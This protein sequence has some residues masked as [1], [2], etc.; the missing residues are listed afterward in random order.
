[1][2]PSVL[3]ETV[4][5]FTARE[6]VAAGLDRPVS[7]DLWRRLLAALDANGWLVPGPGL[8]SV[9]HAGA[10]LEGLSRGGADTGVPLTLTVHYVMTFRVLAGRSPADLA[11]LRKTPGLACMGASE[12]KVGSH[13]AKIS[14][15]ARLDNGGWVLNGLKV[16]TTGGPV[17]ERFLVMAVCG[18]SGGRRDLGVL[19]VPRGTEGFTVSEMPV[20]PGLE[21][22]PHGVLQF[23]NV[24][25]PSGARLDT[26]GAG[27][28]GWT[29]IVK[30]FRQWEDALMASWIAGVAERNAG[31]LAALL[32]E[33][34]EA[35]T[36]VGRLLATA[37]ALLTLARDS[38][39]TLEDENAGVPPADLIARRYGFFEMLRQMQAASEEAGK[40]IPLCGAPEPL[41]KLRGLFNQLQFAGNAR[42]KIVSTLAE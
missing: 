11:A 16:F 19:L 17:G 24:R 36:A 10:V 25:L 12:P 13:P 28:D 20:H 21:C 37:R 41:Q 31:L 34:P 32:R 18:E 2:T 29:S 6:L 5:D 8:P 39:Q 30:P 14:T 26:G 35:K 1:M 9:L 40:F 15:S 27:G 22:A 3:A 42:G 23:E 38:A 4:R 7:A 33:Q